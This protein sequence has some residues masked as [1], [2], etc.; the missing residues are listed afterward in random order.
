MADETAPPI[1]V[2]NIPRGV[3]QSMVR[4]VIENEFGGVRRA[5]RDEIARQIEEGISK[6]L[7]NV[8]AEVQKRA[9]QLLTY[10]IGRQLAGWGDA[11]TLKEHI[12]KEI[13]RR[14]SAL[15]KERLKGLRITLQVDVQ[16]GGE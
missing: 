10:H 7:P 11:N 3:L 6:A 12:A 5:V 4:Q 9:D 2:L 16:G 13:D 1:Q 8:P 14:A 15:L